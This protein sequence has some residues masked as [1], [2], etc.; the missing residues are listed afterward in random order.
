MGI[1][2]RKHQPQDLLTSAEDIALR[3]CQVKVRRNHACLVTV[4]QF[5]RKIMGVMSAFPG[6]RKVNDSNKEDQENTV[7]NRTSRLSS[8]YLH[9]TGIIFCDVTLP[10]PYLNKGAPVV[11]FAVKRR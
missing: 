11:S 1:T 7:F 6:L 9:T 4:C 8:V 3:S 2:R 10:L 5:A